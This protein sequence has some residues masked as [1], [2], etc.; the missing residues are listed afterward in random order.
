LKANP[1]IRDWH[2][3]NYCRDMVEHWSLFEETCWR[4]ASIA[5]I[6][7]AKNSTNPDT[8]DDLEDK[9]VPSPVEDFS[10]ELEE[11]S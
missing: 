3:L 7:E 11:P 8:D 9:H 4:E 5:E 1:E 2:D 10:D 6:L